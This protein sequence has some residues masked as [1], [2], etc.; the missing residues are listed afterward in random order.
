MRLFPVLLAFT[1]VTACSDV[2]SVENSPNPNAPSDPTPP[3]SATRIE[4][5]VTGN[6]NGARVRLSNAI[7]GLGQVTTTLPYITS[8]T[9][10]DSSMFLSLE[11]TPTSYSYNTIYPFMSVQIFADGKLFREATSTDLL[12]NTLS[13]SGTW[14]K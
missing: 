11:A 10:L 1:L 9:T 5:R 12:L 7:D 14:R 4:F 6:A 13:V 8:I 3:V 2:T